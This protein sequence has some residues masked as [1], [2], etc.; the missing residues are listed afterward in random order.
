MQSLNAHRLQKRNKYSQAVFF[1]L[2]GSKCF[3]AAHKHVDEI[4]YRWR[5]SI[6][7]QRE[8]KRGLGVDP[9]DVIEPD[10]E[11]NVF[12]KTKIPFEHVRNRDDGEKFFS[13]S[14]YRKNITL[15]TRSIQF[16]CSIVVVHENGQ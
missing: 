12:P 2:L 3:K 13:L 10:E 7:G 9:D 6:L 8:G 5:G 11:R 15:F 14:D 1:T 16:S 4:Y